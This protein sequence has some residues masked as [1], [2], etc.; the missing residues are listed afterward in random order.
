M[1]TSAPTTRPA[2]AH[3]V[4]VGGGI[5]GLAAARRLAARPD[6]EVTL[7]EAADRLGGKIETERADGFLVE[8]GPDSF[9]AAKPRGAGLCAEAGLGD[10]LLAITPRPHRARV[11]SRGVMHE[12][13]EGLSGLIPTKL[14][15]VL[16]SGLLSPRGKARLAADWVLPA[17]RDAADESLGGFVRRRLGNEAWE[18][19]VEPLTA[20]IFAGD[21]DRLSLLATY[22]QLRRAEQQHGGL[23]RGV[24]ANRP[25]PADGPPKPAFLTPRD[26]LG[27]LVA[28]LERQLRAAGADLRTGVAV[29]GVDR[30]PGGRGWVVRTRGGGEVAA[31]AVVV[32]TPAYVAGDLLLGADPGLA[33]ELR[34]IPHASSAIVS[35]G[36]RRADLAAPLDAHGYLVP[37][38]ERTPVLA[39][40]FTSQK[41][42][43]RAPDGH[44]L[45]RVFLG[46]W[47]RDE[48]LAGPD[49]ALLALA[50]AEVA[51][52]LGASAPPVLGRVRRWHHGMPQ[53]VVG[54]LDRVGRIEAA[55][56]RLPGIELAGNAYRGVGVP[57]CIASG[58]AAADRVA[59]LLAAPG[60]ALVPPVAPPTRVAAGVAD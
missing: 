44:V 42:V 39:C 10:D 49:D 59:A 19:L 35:L 41:W 4:V 13:P 28:A 32:A 21:G 33:F 3:V 54:H 55:A 26:G 38:V 9:L 56:A 46:G 11:L 37:R 12:L 53:Y 36:Y 24:L 2:R 51:Q 60:P 50:V 1:S 57:D 34:A 31:D 45:L 43:G 22:P 16:R 25:A 23:A 6:T 14:T 5:A 7:L 8:A 30:R 52:R 18:R 27:A 20:G 48:M 29:S 15:P 58:E 47:G 17:R 40:T